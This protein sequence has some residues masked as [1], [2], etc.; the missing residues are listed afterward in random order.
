MKIYEEITVDLTNPYPLPKMKAQQG[1]TG[2]GAKI[3]LTHRRATIQIDKEIVNLYAK[4]PNSMNMVYLS[5]KLEGSYPTI[6]GK[7]A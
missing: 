6:Q 7:S 1:N 4:L 3:K 2:R 5:T